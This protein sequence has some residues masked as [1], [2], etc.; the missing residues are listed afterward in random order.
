[1][2]ESKQQE[3]D[4]LQIFKRFVAA[5]NIPIRVD[6]IRCCSPPAPDISCMTVGGTPVAFELT[7]TIDEK[8]AR[9]MS[10]SLEVKTAL[11]SNFHDSLDR[12]SRRKL[13]TTLHNADIHV[14]LDP[15]LTKPG[16]SG[17]VLSIFERLMDCTADDDGG[18]DPTTLPGGVRGI[19]IWRGGFRGPLFSVAGAQNVGDKTVQRVRNKFTKQYEYSGDIELLVHSW[20]RSLLPD[21][22]W[23]DKLREYLQ[24]EFGRSPFR[25][26]W[27]FD[28]HNSSIRF[29]Y[30]E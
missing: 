27:F 15:N 18:L 21:E 4:E 25:Q 19:R 17:V 23:L 13:C 8:L 3:R 29:R 26:I 10:F 11:T 12:A 9:N 16:I 24:K 22:F 30:P 5:A 20:T 28:Y 6:S 7:E 2:R 14:R 1:M